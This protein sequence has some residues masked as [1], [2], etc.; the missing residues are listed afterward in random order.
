MTC[1]N[2]CRTTGFLNGSYKSG[3]K[4]CSTCECFFQP[5][6]EPALSQEL[7]F[8]MVSGN[9]M[10]PVILILYNWHRV[11]NCFLTSGTFGI[12]LFGVQK[13]GTPE[14]V[15]ADNKARFGGA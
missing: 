14:T 15:F 12:R 4:W 11:H 2:F 13:R 3:A 6:L 10:R 5:K 1:T 8:D 9:L 7:H